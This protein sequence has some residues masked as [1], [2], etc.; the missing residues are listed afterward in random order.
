MALGLFYTL[1][2]AQ[3]V[4]LRDRAVSLIMEGKTIMSYSSEGTSVTKQMAM[5]PK[6]ILEECNAALARIN[7][8]KYGATNTSFRRFTFGGQAV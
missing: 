3:V 7:P 6:E 5:P 2:E 4:A 1:P 8:T